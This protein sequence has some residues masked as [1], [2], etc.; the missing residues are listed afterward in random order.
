MGKDG[1]NGEVQQ[2]GKS[3]RCEPGSPPVEPRRLNKVQHPLSH[4][5]V[6]S[7]C[8]RCY[9]IASSLG[10]L[11]DTGDCVYP[12]TRCTPDPLP[13]WSSLPGVHLKFLKIPLSWLESECT[14]PQWLSA[15]TVLAQGFR[16]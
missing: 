8:K 3:A 13:F 2:Q 1:S 12:L 9:R 6:T 5:I 14:Q 15:S 11:S 16:A 4:P 10:G 7:G